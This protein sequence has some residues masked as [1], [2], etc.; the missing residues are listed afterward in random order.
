MA[1]GPYY[2]GT[3]HS[4]SALLSEIHWQYNA[5]LL[6]LIEWRYGSKMYRRSSIP[7]HIKQ[8]DPA[9]VTANVPLIQN[10]LCQRTPAQPDF[11]RDDVP[12]SKWSIEIRMIVFYN[13]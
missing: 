8:T 5:N 4:G 12:Y 3:Y 6:K 1:F 10:M 13:E 11:I 7:P 2:G 9:T